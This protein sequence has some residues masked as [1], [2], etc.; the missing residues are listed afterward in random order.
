MDILVEE[1]HQIMNTKTQFWKLIHK[2][3][4][5]IPKDIDLAQELIIERRE[6][7]RIKIE[8]IKLISIF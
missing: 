7:S 3:C 1:H 2:A 8:C 5:K 6:F 4:S